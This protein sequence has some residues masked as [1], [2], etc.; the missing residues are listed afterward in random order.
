MLC[1]A[2]QSPRSYVSNT[3]ITKID[4]T[5]EHNHAQFMM[6]AVL[7]LALARALCCTEAD[8]HLAPAP[9]SPPR[10]ER[11]FALTKVL[12]GVNILDRGVLDLRG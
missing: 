8:F 11:G 5:L 1:A 10:I 2:R 4:H 7:R 3:Q 9:A 6:H 12:K